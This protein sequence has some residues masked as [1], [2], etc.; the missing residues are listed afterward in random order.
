M[1]LPLLI[2]ALS[3]SLVRLEAPSRV[4]VDDLVEAASEDRSTY[5]FTSVPATRSATEQEI[6]SQLEEWS[7]GLIVPFVQ[8]DVT[9]RRAIGMARYLTI[10]RRDNDDLP[11]AIEIG[12]T[13][14]A[15]S[16]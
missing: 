11:F 13:W 10:R 7:Q 3:G 12:G 6:D 8:I 2:P 5:A 9:S 15:A 16:A 4:F 14:L 1:P